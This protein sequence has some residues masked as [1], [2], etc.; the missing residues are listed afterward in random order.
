MSTPLVFTKEGNKWIARLVS[1][2]ESRVV[3]INR[4]ERD[5]LTVY[6]SMDSNSEKPIEIYNIPKYSR[7]NVI[8]ELDVPEDVNVTI[9]SFS[10]VSSAKI[11]SDDEE[12]G[13]ASVSTLSNLS[14]Q[15]E[16]TIKQEEI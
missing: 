12:E 14:E 11:S 3:E 2:G 7:D 13:A 1:D 10:E 9:V 4:A 16:Q 15:D 8:F 6:V 5:T